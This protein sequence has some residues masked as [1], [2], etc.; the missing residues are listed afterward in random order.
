MTFIAHTCKK[1]YIM[2]IKKQK[3]L[4]RIKVMTVMKIKSIN[5]FEKTLVCVSSSSLLEKVIAVSF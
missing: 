5:L 3:K 1:A 2:K 4:K